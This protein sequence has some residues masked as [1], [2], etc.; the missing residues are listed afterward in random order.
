[1]AKKFTDAQWQAIMALFEREA[2]DFGLPIRRRNSLIL[3][4]FNIRKLGRVAN[5]SPQAWN[6]LAQIGARADLLA[7][8][9]VQDDLQGVKHLKELMGSSYDM[10]ISDTTGNYPGEGTAPER[11]AYLY[12]RSRVQL[13]EVASDIT[14]DRTKVVDSL[15]AFR[16]RFTRAFDEYTEKLTAWEIETEVRK[17]AGLKPKDKPGIRLPEFVTFIRQPHCAAFS[18]GS[19]HS[20]KPYTFLAVNVHLLYGE[21]KEE[22]RKEFLAAVSWLVDRAKNADNMY[23]PNIVFMGDCNLD[24]RDPEKDRK[25]V[26]RL[27]ASLNRTEGL[28]TD[29]DKAVMN[30]PFIDPHPGQEDVFKTAARMKDTYDQIAFIFLDPRFP[31]Y[32]QNRVAGET[33][34]G[35]DYGV[36]NTINLFSQALKGANY[37]DLPADEQKELISHSE[38]DVTDH[39]P[40]WV[41]L[42]MPD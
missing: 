36:F 31:D 22:R 27:L 11:L 24:F 28:E 37:E 19:R 9:E 6:L 30:F 4:S 42:P 2:E 18:M 10:L 15:Y 23:Y 41:R 32:K 25:V 5:R 3:A 1:M 21:D 16:D 38:F 35:F 20:R 12:R 13:R 39:M 26:R 7:V 34:D 33:L 29:P 17:A 40:I 8:Q 14:Y